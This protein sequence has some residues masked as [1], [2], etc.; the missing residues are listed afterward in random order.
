MTSVMGTKP[1]TICQF[2]TVWTLLPKYWSKRASLI[3]QCFFIVLWQYLSYE[4]FLARNSRLTDRFDYAC[5]NTNEINL[6]V[7]TI[8]C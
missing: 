4:V 8:L 1:F 6:E 5:L 2:H 3:N 7:I